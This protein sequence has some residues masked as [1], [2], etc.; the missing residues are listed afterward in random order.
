MAVAKWG[1]KTFNPSAFR[2]PVAE[3]NRP[4]R[5]IAE[6]MGGII[7]GR[8]TLEKYA[9]VIYRIPAAG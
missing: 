5:R 9:S 2:Y 7:I 1:A 8:E 4:S 6:A 3:A